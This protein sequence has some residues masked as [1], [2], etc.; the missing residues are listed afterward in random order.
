MERKMND[1]LQDAVSLVSVG[2]FILIM[3]MW[4]GAI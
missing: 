2:G 3:A 1:A 4:L